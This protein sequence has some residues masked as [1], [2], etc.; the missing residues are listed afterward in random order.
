MECF[1]QPAGHFGGHGSSSGAD[2][3]N[4]FADFSGGGSLEEI[5]AGIGFQCRKDL[6]VV[7]IDGDHDDMQRGQAG[8]ES[9]GQLD[10]GYA[11]QVDIHQYHIR[12]VGGN[13]LQGLLSGAEVAGTGAAMLRKPRSVS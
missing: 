1:H 5:T 8:F 13:G 2:G 9:A 4:C 7:A 12:L 3:M 11:E 6:V 10:S